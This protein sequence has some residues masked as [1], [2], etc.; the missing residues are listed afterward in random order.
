VAATLLATPAA[1]RMAAAV[2]AVVTEL[3]AQDVSSVDQQAT[4]RVYRERVKH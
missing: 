3:L 4:N 2:D 1:L